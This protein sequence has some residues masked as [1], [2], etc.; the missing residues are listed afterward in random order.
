MASATK[1]KKNK[2]SV[3]TAGAIIISILAVIMFTGI[4]VLGYV[5]INILTFINGD[6]SITLASIKSS[7][8]QTTFLYATDSEGKTVELTRLHGT[9]N[10]VWI[11]MED[12]S[13]DMRNAFVALE[14]K[15]FYNHNGVDWK[16][17]I[18]VF[19]KNNDQGGST[20]TQQ[21][22]KNIT[23][24]NDVTYVRKYHEILTALNIEKAYAAEGY[25]AKDVILEAYLN[26]VYLGK[27]CYGVKTAAETY[28]GKDVSELNIAECATIAAITKNPYSS[29]PINHLEKNRKRMEYCLECM[30][31]EDYITQEQ[32]DEALNYELV[33]TNSENYVADEDDKKEEEKKP[34]P[35][36]INSYYVD[37]VIDQVINDLME[38]Q[39]CSYSEASGQIYGG[40][41]QIYTA[42]DLDV[43]EILEDVYVNKKSFVDKKNAQSSM[44]IMDYEGRVVGIIGG[45]GKKEGNRVLNRA[46]DSPRPPGSTIKPLSSYGPAMESNDI[47]W[48]SAVLDKSCTTINGRPWPKNYS[49][50]TGSGSYVTVQNALARSLNTIPARII[51]DML[52]PK[53]SYKYLV[54]K[55]DFT[56][57]V[58]AD[59]D[60]ARLSIGSLSYGMTSL[61]MTAAYCI[62]GSGGKY[63]KPYSYYKVTDANGD[64]LLDNTSNSGEQI[65]TVETAEIMRE[66]MKTVI[67]SSVG[68]GKGYGVSGFETFAK[69]GTTDDYRDRWFA[70]GTPYYFA[71]VWY[72]YDQ[73]KAINASSNPAGDI[74]KAVM[75]RVHKNLADKKFEINGDIVKKYYCAA[76]GKLSSSTTGSSMAGW[77]KTDSLP[78]YCTGNHSGVVA[79]GEE[80]TSAPTETNDTPTTSRNNNPTTTTTRPPQKPTVTPPTTTTT[81]P[82]Q[83]PTDPPTVPAPQPDPAP[84]TPEVVQ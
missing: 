3:S 18:G 66:M 37:F 81:R 6:A 72:G 40:G 76:C 5:G 24:N 67:T 19:L 48:S 33:F 29:D 23:G 55:M 14:D 16:R 11:D 43:Q 65:F 73:P 45:A 47:T 69:T 30:L 4:I 74:F 22:I 15:R 41:L 56:T 26:T 13:Q 79:D 12:I 71:S 17:T 52:G 53:T 84:I 75:D 44:T 34:E 63:Y 35:V 42:V 28:F 8:N 39:H 36:E 1:K 20:I 27:G 60:L 61:E 58:E 54:E 62:Y 80:T 51:K 82:T 49:G 21:L 50:N 2:N 31:G 83:S 57:L 32:Y 25:D 7:L 9:E 68:T 46:V 10:R 77:Y 38:T 78:G 70:G 64:I 59:E